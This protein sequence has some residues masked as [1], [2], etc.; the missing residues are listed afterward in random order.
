MLDTKGIPEIFLL[1]YILAFEL[2]IMHLRMDH[3]RVSKQLSFLFDSLK[4]DIKN[5]NLFGVFDIL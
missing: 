3:K 1:G 4:T 5:T 2:M